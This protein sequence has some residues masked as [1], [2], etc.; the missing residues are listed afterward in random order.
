MAPEGRR[1]I[2]SILAIISGETK[3]YGGAV[4]S[5]LTSLDRAADEPDTFSG[6]IFNAHEAAQNFSH[7]LRTIATR[8]RQAE[9][10]V[11]SQKG[12]GNIFRAFFDDF[13]SQHVIQDFK[14]LHTRHNPFRFR[15][16]ILDKVTDMRANVLL[17]DRLTAAYVV[18]GRS[19]STEEACDSIFCQL[20]DIYRVFDGVDAQLRIID[21]THERIEKRIRTTVRYMDR[22]EGGV[23]DR[24]VTTIKKLA[25]SPISD[26]DTVD[27]PPFILQVPGQIGEDSRYNER[28]RRSPPSETRLRQNDI[29][30][31]LKALIEAKN[32]YAKR[33]T[34]TPQR[35]RDFAIS[36]LGERISIKGSDI[37][38]STIDDF[39]VFQR[40][41]ELPFIFDRR[42]AN[43][44]RTEPLPDLV[45]NE[46]IVFQD[47][48]IIRIPSEARRHDS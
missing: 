4:L 5:V 47:F 30:P 32:A 25:E 11:C 22:D 36:V 10:H 29:D 7:H 48:E 6:N 21:E 42:F 38:I 41:R 3:S 28:K 19:D 43:E 23:I 1:L 40:L 34:V 16:R 14:T 2:Q 12:I 15:S 20:E 9:E 46:Y 31:A 17:M 44:F 24:L 33:V 35:I 8:M 45:E 26:D 27:V 37:K 18:E 39:I 13:I